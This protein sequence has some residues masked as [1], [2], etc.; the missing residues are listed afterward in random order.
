MEK[1]V[2]LIHEHGRPGDTLLAGGTGLIGRAIQVFTQSGYSHAALLVG[3]EHVVEAYDYSITPS[4]RDEGI[5]PITLIDFASRDYCRVLLLR[6]SGVD[7][8]AVVDAAK[9]LVW[10][11]PT[12]PTM[13]LILIGLCLATAPVL[14]VLPRSLSRPIATAQVWLTADGP[15]RMHCSEAVARIYAETG[16]R[17]GKAGLALAWHAT[18][19][20]PSGGDTQSRTPSDDGQGIA[21]STGRRAEKGTWPRGRAAQL[22]AAILGVVDSVWQR[23]RRPAGLRADHVDL[24]VPG[25][26]SRDPGLRVIAAFRRTTGGWSVEAVGHRH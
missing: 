18:H 24:I 23:W 4:E 13:G 3:P 14:K 7:T 25:D 15:T 19:L 20:R 9:R 5:Y 11:S 17:I 22:R 2:G 1:L 21:A 8:D 10:N 16:L 6:P 26:L 12:F